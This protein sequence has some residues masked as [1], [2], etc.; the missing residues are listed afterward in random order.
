MEQ[1]SSQD[2]KIPLRC[3]SLAQQAKGIKA[4]VDEAVCLDLQKSSSGIS[5]LYDDFA[6]VEDETIFQMF[7]NSIS[8]S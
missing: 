4:S 3:L 7:K 8:S 6:Q 2:I 5:A 1:K